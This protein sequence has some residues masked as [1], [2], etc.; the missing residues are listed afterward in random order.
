MLFPWFLGRIL[1]LAILAGQVCKRCSNLTIAARDDPAGQCPSAAG[2]ASFWVLFSPAGGPRHEN[3]QSDRRVPIYRNEQFQ[4]PRPRRA[5]WQPGQASS[6]GHLSSVCFWCG[7]CAV[8]S[9]GHSRRAP[10]RGHF[11]GRRRQIRSPRHPRSLRQ[12]EV[13]PG[14]AAS[15]SRGRGSSTRT[16]GSRKES[17]GNGCPSRPA[18]VF[19]R[20]AHRRG[21]EISHS[22]RRG[23][24][25]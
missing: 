9:R 11:A 17:A 10:G 13:S 20:M 5:L 8:R 22:G 21:E 2:T 18:R 14:P 19:L 15:K 7:G 4:L 25:N 24:G 1:G 23:H 3:M 16:A 12:H 6:L